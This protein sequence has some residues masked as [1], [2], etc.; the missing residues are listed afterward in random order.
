MNPV[1]RHIG[2]CLLICAGLTACGGGGDADSAPEPINVDY[3]TLRM[4][5]SL[6]TPLQYARNDEQVLPALRNGLRIM[7]G[8]GGA[9]STLITTVTP[10]VGG[11][12]QT[13]HSSTTVQVDGVDEADSVKYDGR[14]IYAVR[15]QIVPTAPSQAVLSR[16]VLEIS[17]TDAQTASVEAA[18]KFVI[19]GE[20][21]AEPLLYQLQTSQGAAEYLIAVSQNFQG[22]LMPQVPIAALVIQPDRTTVQLLDVRDPQNVSQS[23]KLELDGWLRASRMIGDTL[24]LVSS[25]R[26]RLPDLILPA[27]TLEKREA[28][29]RRIRSSTA[30]DLFPTYAENGGARRQL[31]SSEGCLIAQQTGDDDGHTDLIV[32]AAINV[33]TRRVTDV[34]CLSTNINSVYMSRE[35]LYVAGSGYRSADSTSTTVLHKFGI[36]DGDI[37]YRATGAVTGSIG[38]SAPSYFMDEHEGDLR[39]VTS[40]N[41]VHRLTVMRESGDRNLMLVSSLPNPARPEPIGKPGESIYAVRFMNERAYVVTFRVTDPLYVIDLREPADPVIAGELEIPG[42][43]TYLRPVGASG[44][45]LLLSVGQPV[46]AN[47]RREGVKVELFDVRDIANPQS[48]GAET[49]G[50]APTYTEALHEPHALTFLT[51]PGAEPRHRLAVPIHVFDSSWRYSGLHLFE[52]RN[53]NGSPHLH[54]QGV[55]RT[56]DSSNGASGP[57]F[58]APNRGVLHGDSVFAVYGENVHS[59]LWQNVPAN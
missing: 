35:S 49:F 30:R 32:I 44:S 18:G 46:A 6:E 28:N 1:S 37:R 19:E 39:I 36:N 11:T 45:E 25:Y 47:G 5:Q 12:A 58:T 27:D 3:S 42:V 13:P 7:S 57:K 40:N 29:E 2:T 34:N 9:A 48:L 8:T 21:S 20:Q 43:S 16:N 22:W 4:A 17:R 38:W 53:E 14:F 26:P 24:Y 59:S 54:F 51:L 23:W 33:R 41:G 10:T 55:I 31:A 50:S 15:R 56:E 52:V